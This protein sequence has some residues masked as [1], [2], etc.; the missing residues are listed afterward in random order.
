MRKGIADGLYE[1]ELIADAC[2]RTTEERHQV[3][4]HTRMFRDCFRRG[5]PTFR[6]MWRIS[7]STPGLKYGTGEAYVLEL[8]GIRTPDIFVSVHC[9]DRDHDQV[10]FAHAVNESVRYERDVK[11]RR[12]RSKGRPWSVRR[13]P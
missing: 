8:E 3:T 2:A 6:P 1:R 12:T 5:L 4:P 7:I 9:I 13:C 11:A 10:P